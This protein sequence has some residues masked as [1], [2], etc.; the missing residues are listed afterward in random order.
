MSD[1]ENFLLNSNSVAAGDAPG[2]QK[3]KEAINQ[4]LVNN[5]DRLVSVLYRL[6]VSEKKLK[7]L[8]QQHP[9]TDAAEII[10]NL[11]V[12]RQQQKIKTREQFKPTGNDIDEEERW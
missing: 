9:D 6:D 7:G 1:I 4:L 11:I 2:F 5:F 12:E 10:A 3:L 8:L